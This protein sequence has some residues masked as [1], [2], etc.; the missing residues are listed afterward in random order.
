MGKYW[1]CEKI[2]TVIIPSEVSRCRMMEGLVNL[3]QWLHLTTPSTYINAMLM[4]HYVNVSVRLTKTAACSSC[5]ARLMTTTWSSSE[6]GLEASP[7]QRWQN[8]VQHTQCYLL[9]LHYIVCFSVVQ[10]CGFAQTETEA[11][12]EMLQSVTTVM[13]EPT[14]VNLQIC[15]MLR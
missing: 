14:L 4:Q 10:F 3:R 1:K 9:K 2:I 11:N 6:E 12:V 15:A 7:A 13:F 5:W 8:E